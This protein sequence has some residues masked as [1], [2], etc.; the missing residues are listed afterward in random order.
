MISSP[1]SVTKEKELEKKQYYPIRIDLFRFPINKSATLD[2]NKFEYIMWG[3]YDR[4][5]IN[6]D[7]TT[8][9]DLFIDGNSFIELGENRLER[10]FLAG[11][12]Q[13]PLDDFICCSMPAHVISEFKLNEDVL[14]K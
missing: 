10:Q 1:L 11:Y 5:L 8:L 4:A 9:H 2:D 12:S 3:Y 13:K 14:G 7:I 6:R